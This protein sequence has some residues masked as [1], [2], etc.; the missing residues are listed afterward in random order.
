[1]II[2]AGHANKSAIIIT[3][4]TR[5]VTYHEIKNTNIDHTHTRA[6][7]HRSQFSEHPG[8]WQDRTVG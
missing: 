8:W 6:H 3:H 1:M 7:L 5:G 2:I 4:A